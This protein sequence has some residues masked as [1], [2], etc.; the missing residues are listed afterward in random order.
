MASFYEIR[1][2]TNAVLKR[3]G[4]VARR[5]PRVLKSGCPVLGAARAG[6]FSESSSPASTE[7]SPHPTLREISPAA[8]RISYVVP[9]YYSH[10][11]TPR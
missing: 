9:T 11:P 6:P 5:L 1:S 3:D 10:N 8:L 7:R 2:S 4:R